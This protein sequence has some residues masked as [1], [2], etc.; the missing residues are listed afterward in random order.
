MSNTTSN[1][2]KL[3][4]L[5]T[6]REA[7]REAFALKPSQVVVLVGLGTCGLAAGGRPVMQAIQ[8]ELLLQAGAV[9][10]RALDIKVRATGCAGMCEAEVLVEVQRQGGRRIMYG[11]VKPDMA[12]R[13]VAEDAVGGNA[14]DDWVVHREEPGVKAGGV[15]A[16]QLRIVLNNCGTIDPEL[17]EHYIARGG[18]AGLERVLSGMPPQEVIDEVKRSGLRG[19]GGAGFP[20]GLK[21]EFARQAAGEKKY[22]LCNADEGD[23]GAFMDRSLLE[24]DP[25][26]VLEGMIIGAYAIGSDEGYIYCR[27]E[28]PL[29]IKRLRVAMEQ[30]GK[31]GLLGENILGTGFSFKLHI[32]EGAGA[33]VC[34]EE[35]AL[36]AS[37]MGARGMP[38]PRPPF[39]AQRGLW[40]KP[41]N[42]NNVE[43]WANVPRILAQG[44]DWFAGIGTEKSKGTKVFAL[45]GRIKKT[46][47]VEVP[48]GLALREIVYDIG[49]GI[50]FDRRFKAVQIG[51]PSG[52]CIPESLLDTSIDYD[53]LIRAGAMMGSGGMVVV[54]ETTC[55]V[56]LARYFMSFV[57][58]ESCGKC[59]PCR[60]GTKQMLSIMERIVGG[61]SEP[62]DIALLE[63]LSVVV[64]DGSL[65][66]LGKTAPNPV[67]TT[68]RYFRDEFEAH[69]MDRTCPSGVCRALMKYYIDPE[70]CRGCTR[71]SKICPVGAVTGER[72]KPHWINTD[73]CTKC[74]LCL[75]KCRFEAIQA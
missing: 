19:R 15:L 41:T 20:T 25:H 32:K 55:M 70:K 75:E 38:R 30:A 51:G 73:K 35:T 9:K 50:Q 26:A 18:Y 28:Y 16:K 66:G 48:M 72:N 1:K 33:F 12:R 58:S 45:A 42:I 11:Q 17:I 68:L 24:G 67:L 27:A 37:I 8:D 6:L 4:Q 47:L 74:R 23:P 10:E 14:I 56:E 60:E 39:P 29:A 2:I 65:C 7:C 46:G 22:V 61:K 64:K 69:V 34:G 57:Q 71:C 3:E 52:G 59:V 54:D 63:E 21:W 5:P 49:G 43:T 36:I 40:D 53:S 44:S 62:G 31:I 13:I